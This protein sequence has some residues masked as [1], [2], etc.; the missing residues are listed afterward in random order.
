MVSAARR[1]V[2]QCT[3]KRVDAYYRVKHTAEGY[4]VSVLVVYRYEKSQPKVR[5]GGD[6]LVSLADDG[7][8]KE[9]LPGH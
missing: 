8:V 3:R 9:A 7:T 4:W 2:E 5:I 6:W 1:C